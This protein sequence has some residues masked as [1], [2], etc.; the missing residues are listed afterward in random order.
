ML[1]LIALLLVSSL[2]LG[3]CGKDKDLPY[4]FKG[5]V[6][7]RNGKGIPN[8][9][10]ELYAG[11]T[12]RYKL[13]LVAKTTT[14]SKGYYDARFDT[15]TTT[16]METRVKADSYFPIHYQPIPSGSIGNNVLVSNPVLYKLATLRIHF[17]NVPPSS[18]SD[19]IMFFH[20]NLYHG[21]G[22]D[23]FIERKVTRGTYNALSGYYEGSDAE[24]YELV[25]T[26]GDTISYIQWHPVQNQ[27]GPKIVDSVFV[28]GGAEGSFTI[29][30]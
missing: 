27:S 20:H 30:Y 28:P 1:R 6:T 24:G 8:A 13:K 3:S 10:V 21:E 9:S 17:R 25:K 18:Q 26:M 2:L 23:T 4:L 5:Q 22:F 19:R 14:D 16:Y 11:D 7:D 29:T 15:E 12:W